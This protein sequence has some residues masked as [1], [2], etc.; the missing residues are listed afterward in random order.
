MAQLP[1]L[2]II[3]DEPSLLDLLSKRFEK[4]NICVYTSKNLLEAKNIINSN[5]PNVIILDILLPNG[6]GE[7]FLKELRK[8]EKTKNIPVII[9][10]N[11]ADENIKKKCLE[12]GATYYLVKTD[13]DLD[14]LVE[15]V[16]EFFPNS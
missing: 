2:L 13:I 12:S 4:E 6:D 9:L 8:D 10:T 16:K 15:K 7:L 14:Q 1:R 11:L 5:P 3:E